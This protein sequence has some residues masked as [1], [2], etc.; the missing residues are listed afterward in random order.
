MST[1]VLVIDDDEAIAEYLAANLRED[2]LDVLTASTAGEGLATLRRVR[3]GIALV[4]LGLPDL[5]GLELLRCIR[6]GEAGSQDVGVI[7]VSARADEQDRIRA[8]ERGADDYIAKPFGYRELLVR[9][10]ALRNRIERSFGSVLEVGPLRIDQAARSVT[11]AGVQLRLPAKEYELLVALARDPQRVQMK[12]D[13]LERV[14]GYRGGSTRTLD[15]HASRLRRRL[16]EATGEAWI[17]NN[18]S[19]G[20]S[21]RAA[22]R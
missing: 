8:F 17:I 20:Y 21:L 22:D 18:W 19:V 16:V 5:P 13:L 10:L 2:G 3:P 9:T 1:A 12:D 4:D 15:S 11:A 14:W 7:V 6:D